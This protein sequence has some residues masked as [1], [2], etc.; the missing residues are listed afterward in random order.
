MP[1]MRA[2]PAPIAARSG[3]RDAMRALGLL[4]RRGDSRRNRGTAVDGWSRGSR[5]GQAEVRDRQGR[6][7][8][9]AGRCAL[10]RIAGRIRAAGG[11]RPSA[12]APNA[13]SRLD[14][15]GERS[16]R[17]WTARR[18]LDRHR[19]RGLPPPPGADAAK[20][21]AG[22]CSAGGRPAAAA[23]SRWSSW[24][25]ARRRRLRLDLSRWRHTDLLPSSPPAGTHTL[26]QVPFEANPT[27]SRRSPPTGK[28]KNRPCKLVGL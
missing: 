17:R 18:R 7:P 11:Y 9:G 26:L 8:T 25:L 3:D 14:R 16:P 12:R 2:T 10:R 24:A 1:A 6:R 27:L 21:P 4:V 5:P 15:P 22:C 28:G 23:G 13:A 20:T 19:P